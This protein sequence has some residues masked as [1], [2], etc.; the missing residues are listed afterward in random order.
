MEGLTGQL[1]QVTLRRVTSVR[2]VI[3]FPLTSDFEAQLNSDIA[4]GISDGVAPFVSTCDNL[5]YD[6]LFTDADS[7]LVALP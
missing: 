2:L 4:L 6:M 5:E 7:A 1:E 3:V